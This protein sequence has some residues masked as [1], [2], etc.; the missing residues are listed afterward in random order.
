MYQVACL[1]VALLLAACA[2]APTAEYTKIAKPEDVRGDEIDTF[3]LRA[4]HIVISKAADKKDA[5]G[6]A[7]SDFDI[8]SVP[9]EYVSFKV[10][11]RRADSW[12]IKTNLSL[13]KIDNTALVKE[14]GT[15]LTDSR[16]DL[17]AKYGAAAVKVIGAAAAFTA[18]SPSLP[19][20]PK[21]IDVQV[22]LEANKVGRDPMKVDAGEGVDIEIGP[23]PPDAI[24]SDFFGFP[25]TLTGLIYGA[26]RDARVAF[27]ADGH[28]VTRTVKISDPRYLEV[29]S[30]PVAGKV[31]MHSA[32]GVSVSSNK[33]AADSAATDIAG[34]L[35]AQGKAIKDAIDAA[36]TPAAAASG[37]AKKP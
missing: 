27:K 2:A 6:A 33:Q 25:K 10:G 29:A 30:F 3:Y 34:A 9:A 32:C 18:A 28:S 4:S 12:G 35:A 13:T 5:T 17:I 16:A 37:A 1:T 19:P 22:L 36:K 15:D 23:V 31:T 20:L 24:A 14:A 8:V 26:C 7:A 21:E 11:V